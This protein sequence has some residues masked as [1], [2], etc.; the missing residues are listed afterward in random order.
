MKFQRRLSRGLQSLASYTFSHSIDLA[1]TDAFANYLNTPGSLTNPN[2]DRGNPDFDIRHSFT[3]GLTYDVPT[4]GS[5][6]VMREVLG[7]W[8]LDGFVLARSA[9]PVDVIGAMVQAGGIALY[10]RPNV[11]A[12]V[13]LVGISGR[14]DLQ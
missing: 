14:Q 13:P 9:P 2:I 7:G 11:I 5:D 6:K 10:P 4:P 1:S 8:S 12:G 3:T